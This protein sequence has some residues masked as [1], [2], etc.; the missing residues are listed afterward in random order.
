MVFLY[1][2]GFKLDHKTEFGTTTS[3]AL[4][5]VLAWRNFNATRQFN[6]IMPLIYGFN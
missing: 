1:V 4:R 2:A 6:F 3:W 5:Y